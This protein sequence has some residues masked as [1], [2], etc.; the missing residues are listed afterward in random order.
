MS[1]SL[2]F[3]SIQVENNSFL[4]T[5]F[6]VNHLT[7]FATGYSSESNAID[8]DLIFAVSSIE[9]NITICIL[10]IMTILFGLFG[11]IWAIL[12]DKND[13]VRTLQWPNISANHPDPG[14]G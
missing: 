2:L 1:P 7:S 9:D 5:G 8:F 10:I 11:M 6:S 13:N 3:Y 14:S 12:R 4:T